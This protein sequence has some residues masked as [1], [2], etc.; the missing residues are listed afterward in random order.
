MSDFLLI[1]TCARHFLISLASK[2]LRLKRLKR[3]HLVCYWCWWITK[4]E[5]AVNSMSVM[6]VLRFKVWPGCHLLFREFFFCSAFQLFRL[7]VFLLKHRGI[8]RHWC[9]ETS[10]RGRRAGSL[11][12][13][14]A[15]GPSFYCDL[16]LQQIKGPANNAIQWSITYRF[17][18]GGGGGGNSPDPVFFFFLFPINLWTTIQS[19]L[20]A[21]CSEI[22][23]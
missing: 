8:K 14:A 17:Y 15:G 4:T 20:R 18:F 12:S 19:F 13:S 6:G 21:M 9:S 5:E 3:T 2:S 16:S 23:L 11:S 22:L 1:Q 7:F 10:V